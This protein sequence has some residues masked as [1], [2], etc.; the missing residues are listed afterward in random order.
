[1]EELVL[2][3]LT[4][5]RLF[6]PGAFP[7]GVSRI[8]FPQFMLTSIIGAAQAFKNLAAMGVPKQT[9]PFK[10]ISKSYI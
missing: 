10:L 4:P 9:H 2:V 1:M 8:G 7:A 6:F 3:S 5:N